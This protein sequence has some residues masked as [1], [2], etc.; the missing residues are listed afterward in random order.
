MMCRII[1]S[2]KTGKFSGSAIFR[3]FVLCTM[4]LLGGESMVSANPVTQNNNDG[5]IIRICEIEIHPQYLDEYLQFAREV[6]HESV[7]KEPGVVSIYPMQILK[8]ATQIRILE[9]Y[10]SEE[11]YKSHISTAHFK[12]YKEGTLHMVKSLALVD[13]SQLCPEN[14]E[15]I[16]RK[17]K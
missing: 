9:I 3:A 1:S 4:L 17:A 11:A 5:M 8:D 7:S 13:N 10:R 12:K 15:L 14:F 6:A 16:F 2:I